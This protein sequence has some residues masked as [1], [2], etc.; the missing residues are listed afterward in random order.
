MTKNI[1]EVTDR[2][3]SL[4]CCHMSDNHKSKGQVE[5][6]GNEMAKVSTL[7]PIPPYRKICITNDGIVTTQ[8]AT[9]L[10][11]CTYVSSLG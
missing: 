6:Q 7:L 11:N 4:V 2:K 10:E 1:S 9:M 3:A 8:G 5:G